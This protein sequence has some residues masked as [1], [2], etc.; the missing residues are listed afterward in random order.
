MATVQIRKYV[1]GH[2]EI[3][4]ELPH[5][6]VAIAAS[7]LPEMALRAFSVRGIR[8]RDVAS[9]FRRGTGHS[10]PFRLRERGVDKIVEISVN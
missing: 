4:V 2:H 10:T 8:M 9:A 6:L 3:T 5:T 1:N 7:I